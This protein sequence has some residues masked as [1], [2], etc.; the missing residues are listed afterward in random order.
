[1]LLQT[2]SQSFSPGL[3]SPRTRPP[4]ALLSPPPS[5]R[6]P[7]NQ[8][9][10]LYRT[11]SLDARS[12]TPSPRLHR[13]CSPHE[14]YGTANL[15]D[16]SRS[17]SPDLAPRSTESGRSAGAPPRKPPG[18]IPLNTTSSHVVA[19]NRRRR[20]RGSM[21]ASAT[22]GRMPHVLPSPTITPD[23]SPGQINFPRLIASPSTRDPTD[24]SHCPTADS[25]PLVD[26][27]SDSRP[28][29][30]PV[31]ICLPHPTPGCQRGG[32]GLPLTELSG[33]SDPSASHT[34]A[35]SSTT[36]R[37]SHRYIQRGMSQQLDVGSRPH[38]EP[39]PP[40][41]PRWMTSSG[42]V[43]M[44]RAAHSR[45]VTTLPAVETVRSTVIV[46]VSGDGGSQRL[47]GSTP[48]VNAPDDSDSDGE[49][50]C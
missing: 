33:S 17:P 7:F 27:S 31:T 29:T 28:L 13:P 19:G 3:W 26:S 18:G 11:T 37:S 21:A 24:D 41:P 50:W 14:Y 32:G 1:L 12:R 8:P 38:A 16:R 43:D 25:S 36:T 20:R 10:P 30:A 4:D 39:R 5:R 22:V 23:R 45:S 9:P 48:Y 2:R 46:P 6:A 40:P 34:P 44:S 49:G 42:T 15:T 35:S 47:F